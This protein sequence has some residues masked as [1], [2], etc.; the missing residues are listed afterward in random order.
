MVDLRIANYGSPPNRQRLPKGEPILSSINGP[1]LNLSK[2][3]SYWIVVCRDQAILAT[4]WC[5]YLRH[6]STVGL[7]NNKIERRN[8]DNNIVHS[9]NIPTVHTRRSMHDS[10]VLVSTS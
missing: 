9:V 5:P 8:I 3:E 6:V 10:A 4:I 2:L 1:G 7:T